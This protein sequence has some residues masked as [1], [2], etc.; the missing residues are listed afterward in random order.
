[1][2]YDIYGIL[3]E[4]RLDVLRKFFSQGKY[5]TIS[6]DFREIVINSY[7]YIYIYIWRIDIFKYKYIY[8]IYVKW[9]KSSA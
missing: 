2:T 6:R 7:N 4:M 5:C 8:V 1:M 9:Q 3:E